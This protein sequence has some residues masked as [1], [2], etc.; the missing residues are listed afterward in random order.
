[1]NMINLHKETIGN[2]SLLHLVKADIADQALPTVIYFHGFNGEKESSLT[3]AYK[4]VEKGLRV[5]LP[6]SKHHGD[7]R[8]DITARALDLAFWEIILQNISELEVIKDYYVTKG[9]TDPARIG[10]G[11]TSMGGIATY[12][13]LAEHSW[14]KAGAVLMGAPKITDYAREL[15][16]RFNRSH[17]EQLSEAD[18]EG[19]LE[20]LQ[21]FDLSVHP[22]KLQQRPLL[23][24]HGKE[25][26]VVPIRFSQEFYEQIKED[27][28]SEENLLFIEEAGRMHNLSKRSMVA[29][30]DWFSKHL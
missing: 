11:G 10:V 19:P 20:M 28:D 24:W 17:E 8:G 23:I 6:D 15:I 13:A 1:M 2:I 25:D 29:A 26:P 18:V 16:A 14:I 30:A 7:R 5:I 9:M 4:M 22:E 27:Y 12:A 3:P 21:G